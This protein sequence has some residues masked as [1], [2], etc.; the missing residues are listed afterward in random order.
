MKRPSSFLPVLHPVLPAL[1]VAL[2]L[3]AAPSVTSA[4]QHGF[5]DQ[6]QVIKPVGFSADG[7][8]F[9]YIVSGVEEVAPHAR[10]FS[11]IYFLDVPGNRF[12]KPK[13][14]IAR[15]IVTDGDIKELEPG[16]FKALNR[17]VMRRS[18]GALAKYGIVPGGILGDKAS[19]T[20]K[21][22][23]KRN[24]FE[25][26]GSKFELRLVPRRHRTKACRGQRTKI[27]TLGLTNLSDPKK[28]LKVLQRDKKLYRSRGCPVDYAVHRSA[29]V[30]KNSIVAFVYSTLN[31]NFYDTPHKVFR[32]LVIGGTMVAFQGKTAKRTWRDPVT[33]MEFVRVPG[34][35]FKMGCHAKAGKCK[36]NEKPART[37][38]LDGF[39]MGKYE[40]TQGQWKWI[41]GSNPPSGNNKGGK[42]AVEYVP[43]NDVQKFIR[44]LNA[45]SSAKFRLPSEAQWEYACRAGGKAVTYGTGNDRVSSGTALYG[46]TYR[47]GRIFPVG[48]YQANSLGLHDMSGSVWE[49]VQDKFT[50]YGY[51]GTNNPINER[52]GAYRVFRG[53]GW[54][55]KP[56]DLRCSNR[57]HAESGYRT[58]ALG[59]RLVRVR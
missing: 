57:A 15:K 33:G 39:W 43:W 1:L 54:L 7:K 23:K 19:V 59:F 17:I 2:L 26:Q 47:K 3:I 42:Y 53:G 10:H 32:P 18:S 36:D 4:N 20:Q 16:I 27:F 45:R 5:N 48:G 55:S 49:W 12:L 44:K 56:G 58:G 31:S 21:G 38:R 22:G 13:R 50:K 30:H 41:M 34:G 35:S 8:Y 52:S 14:I 28:P 24:N 6:W 40:V 25:H 51:V 46:Q 11:R 29:Y 9:A 37:V